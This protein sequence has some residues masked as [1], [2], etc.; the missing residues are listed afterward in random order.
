MHPGSACSNPSTIKSGLLCFACRRRME[1]S[2]EIWRAYAHKLMLLPPPLPLGV[3]VCKSNVI[4]L[5]GGGGSGGAGEEHAV[6]AVG[7]TVPS[8]PVREVCIE[9]RPFD[10]R[11][12]AD[13]AEEGKRASLCGA[14]VRE[15]CAYELCVCGAGAELLI[16]DALKVLVDPPRVGSHYVR[17]DLFPRSTRTPAAAS[18]AGVRFARKGDSMNASMVLSLPSGVS[19][20]RRHGMNWRGTSKRQ[21][22]ACAQSSCRWRALP[23]C[24]R[25]TRAAPT[26]PSAVQTG[27]ACAPA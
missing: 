21:R 2:R 25:P 18:H 17:E 11:R 23:A 12:P 27:P 26:L 13:G 14:W 20:S 9:V 10:H 19:A 6:V 1:R 24:S 15:F 22:A 16:P 4:A 8:R 3:R 7:P 5:W